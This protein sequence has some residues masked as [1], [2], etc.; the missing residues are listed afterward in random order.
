MADKTPV[1]LQRDGDVA[2][3]VLSDPPLNLFGAEAFASLNDCLDEL[4]REGARCVVW[5]AEGEVFTGGYAQRQRLRPGRSVSGR[6]HLPAAAGRGAADRGARGSDAGA[7]PWAVP[8]RGPRGLARLR[9]DLG[10]RVAPVGARRGGRQADPRRRRKS[11]QRM[12][13][14]PAPARAKEF[15]MT[16]GLYP[17]S[18]MERW[19]VVNRVV[20]DELLDKG[21]RFAH[22]LA[23]SPTKA[24]GA[25]KQIL[26][27]FPPRRRRGG[28]PRDGRGRGLAVRDR[29]PAKRGRVVPR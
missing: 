19:N 2:S 7:G 11:A 20:D 5:R 15:V 9:H 23:D 1:T 8:D 6:R 29:G 22:R 13:R 12:A 27:G 18:T 21:M 10:D 25:T 3:L 24:H 26:R 17:A 16:A 14:P 4:D 28:R